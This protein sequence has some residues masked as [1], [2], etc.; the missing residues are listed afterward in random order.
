MNSIRFSDWY[1]GPMPGREHINSDGEDE[2]EEAEEEYEEEEDLEWHS[3]LN[4]DHHHFRFRVQDSTQVQRSEQAASTL[5]KTCPES[6][7][8]VRALW[9]RKGRGTQFFK[10]FHLQ[11]LCISPSDDIFHLDLGT[12][13][14]AP[15]MEWLKEYN[16]DAAHD[17][18]LMSR[19]QIDYSTFQ[20][21]AEPV[22]SDGGCELRD[23]SQKFCFQRLD[24]PDSCQKAKTSL[25]AVFRNASSIY[26]LPSAVFMPHSLT[27]W[28]SY[29]SADH[30]SGI[31]ET[32]EEER[33][34][35]DKVRE[36]DTE[37]KHI[38]TRK[39]WRW[40]GRIDRIDRCH[41]SWAA[42]REVYEEEPDDEESDQ[43]VPF[44]EE[45]G[46][47]QPD[48]EEPDEEAPNEDNT[49]EEFY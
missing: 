14:F 33:E 34:V 44:E 43:E 29:D 20:Q 8:R 47:E 1:T 17:V 10:S 28:Q 40:D 24:L 32:F 2:D 38:I 22:E 18:G 36:G 48:E 45:P 19:F 9:R 49:G 6:R 31:A 13:L 41:I 15:V 46:E 3:I 11:R 23:L 5:W 39:R 37:F 7:A 25:T 42:P 4:D 21:L 26:V 27:D 35:M 30:Q 16:L 12:E